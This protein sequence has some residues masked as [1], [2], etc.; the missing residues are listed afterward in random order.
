MKLNVKSEQSQ[1][2]E[3]IR[4]RCFAP[5]APST[6]QWSRLSVG[7]NTETGVN[8]STH[9]HQQTPWNGFS[10]IM[11]NSKYLLPYGIVMHFYGFDFLPL[12]ITFMAWTQ[13]LYFFSCL[14]TKTACL[15]F[16]A[17]DY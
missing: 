5:T 8:S 17:M 3:D 9:W 14:Q 4:R 1:T 7:S 15:S 10:R 13:L 11:P 16:R 6:Q 12:F 2:C